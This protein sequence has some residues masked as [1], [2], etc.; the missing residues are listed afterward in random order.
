MKELR[1][2]PND[3]GMFPKPLLLA[4][5]NVGAIMDDEGVDVTRVLEFRGSI[6]IDRREVFAFEG[7]NTNLKKSQCSIDNKKG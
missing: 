1:V 4:C 6:D 7:S 3:I 2:F 5:C